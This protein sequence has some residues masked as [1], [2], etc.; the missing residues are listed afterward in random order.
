MID[1]EDDVPDGN[2]SAP[3]HAFIGWLV[4]AAG[5]AVAWFGFEFIWGTGYSSA[6]ALVTIAGVGLSGLGLLVALDDVVE[7]VTGLPTPLDELWSRWL[8][9]IV[10]GWDRER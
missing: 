7:H 1:P 5:I 6:G 3:H 9:P 10:T 4:Q 8:A 2:A